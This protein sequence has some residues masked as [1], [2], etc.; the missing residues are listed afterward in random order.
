MARDY[1]SYLQDFGL[2]GGGA[3]GFY[4]NM[5]QK[6]PGVGSYLQ[7][8]QQ[9]GNAKYIGNT[10]KAAAKGNAKEAI[11]SGIG[12]YLNQN[13]YIAGINTFNQLT[14]G[15][16]FDKMLGMGPKKP[17][18][19]NAQMQTQA[20]AAQQM[21]DDRN[22]YLSAANQQASEQQRYN[23]YVDAQRNILR[24]I[25]T[26]GPSARSLA[27]MLGQ[28][29]NVNE[30]AAGAARSNVAS[31]LSKR[32]LT[33]SGGIGAGAMA[34]VETGL[35]GQQ[36]QQRAAVMNQV[37]QDVSQFRGQMLG[38]DAAASAQAGKQRFDL[39]DSAAMLPI[40]ERMMANEEQRLQQ[41]RDQQMF[42]RRQAEQES[43]GKFT[44]QLF[45]LIYD[46]YKRGVTRR[47]GEE[48]GTGFVPIRDTGAPGTN[49]GA[50]TG[51][52]GE[53]MYF[54]YKG[55]T[56]Y[57]DPFSGTVLDA[58]TG[59][60]VPIEYSGGEQ[61]GQIDDKGFYRQN[62]SSAG[63]VDTTQRTDGG[64]YFDPEAFAQSMMGGGIEPQTRA[65]LDQNF[66]YT[67]PGETVRLP[68]YPGVV[69]FRDAQGYWRK[70]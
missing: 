65:I 52:S 43:I 39:M 70:R 57:R 19:T 22:A 59:E 62:P 11:K 25:Q 68:Q 9:V 1:L 33:P 3:G 67:N 38:V 2:G 29:A 7:R 61:F 44:G 66:S 64:Q 13:P 28:F 55:R 6:M 45:P 31:N 36:G 51:R 8:G 53:N 21:S 48:D 14:G 34:A 26:N 20:N 17:K 37:M 42:M 12:Y 63:D 16:R 54:Q 5:N 41:S 50:D 30:Q 58:Q 4:S 23:D 49:Y 69:F 60:E 24:D 18:T 56:V 10:L 15:I 46:E 40:R 32:G 35:A 27:P 47:N